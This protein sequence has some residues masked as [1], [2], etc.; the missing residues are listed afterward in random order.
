MPTW[1]VNLVL[2]YVLP[3]L[4]QSLT[5]I[6]VEYLKV[7]AAYLGQK[8]PKSVVLV[9]AS[10]VA[11]GAN[12]VQTVLTGTPLPPGV[13]ALIAMLINE[14]AADLGKQPPTPGVHVAM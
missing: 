12:Q 7:A 8:L 5:P 11:E 2:P 1:L 10:A 9:L 4:M 3:A 13:A 6:L 14:F